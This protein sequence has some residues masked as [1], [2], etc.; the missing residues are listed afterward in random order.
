MLAALLSATVLAAGV[1]ACG[2]SANGGDTSE[3]GETSAADGTVL[4][5][6]SAAQELAQ[7]FWA[8][9]FAPAGAYPPISYDAIGSEEGRRRFIDGEAAFAGS[10][11]PL[12]GKELS[13]ALDRC[14][15][16]ELIELPA[17]ISAITIFVNLKLTAM[18]LS[19]QTLA[20]IFDGEITRWDDP[21][22]KRENPTIGPIGFPPKLPITP[23]G[24]SKEPEMTAQ[25]TAYLAEG[26]PGAWD[27]GA[28]DDWPIPESATTRDATTAAQA[29]GGKRGSI[30][31]ADFSHVGQLFGVTRILAAG[32]VFFEPNTLVTTLRLQGARVDTEL[33]KGPRMIPIE[34][35]KKPPA[36]AY[37]LVL[38]SY[39]I[40]CTAYDSDRETAAVNAYVN[41]VVSRQGQEASAE[42][43][44][45]A[46][47]PPSLSKRVFAAAK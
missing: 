28:S 42:A 4:G 9:E 47:L 27:Y 30:G 41:Y 6:G 12:E 38:V 32:G 18:A 45:S 43:V 14:R 35:R 40:A 24:F 17:Y 37:P 5:A 20:K 11:T 3:S 16:G 8:K 22:V 46:F 31:Y 15:P 1:A 23:V 44:G 10:D 34:V 36:R 13:E 26:A 33:S 39:L 2:G 25:L 7:E 21:T 19:P 29:V